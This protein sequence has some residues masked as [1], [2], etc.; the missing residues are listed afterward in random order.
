MQRII[1]LVAA[2]SAAVAAG[3]AELPRATPESVGMSGERLERIT[4]LMQRYVDERRL[5]GIQVLV[6]RDGKVVF[7]RVAGTRGAGDATPLP[8]D[9][10]YR[11]Y[12]MSKPITAVALM[13]LY[14]EGRFQ[15]TDPVAKYAPELARLTVWKDG[16]EVP[17]TN[18]MTM[19]QLLTHTAG[20]SYGFD[21]RDPVD[22]RYAEAG[23]L[24][25]AKD[26]DDF[27][28]RLASVPL[29]YEPG[30]QWHYSV[31]VDVT[32]AIVERLAGQRFDRFLKQ[33]ILDP[34]GMHDTFF[35][36]PEAK[37]PRLLP[38]QRWNRA[39]QALEGIDD[40]RQ[41]RG[42]TFFSGGGGLV[43][44]ARDYLRFAEMLRNGGELDGVRL[45]SPKTVAFMTSDH[46]PASV[47]ASGSGETPGA[48]GAGGN[49]GF[50]FG[51]G[52][53]VVTSAAASGVLGSAGEYNWGGAAGTVF[54]VDPVEDVVVVAMIQLMGSPW[55]LRSELRVLASQALLE[56]RE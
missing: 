20:F 26:L 41:Y 16:A 35:E 36:V 31:A 6:A 38:N 44:T 43:S 29:K 14:E 49:R 24:S 11:I 28:R 46:L 53:G 25:Q 8:A 23:V 15:L 52:F 34:L 17:A 56:T 9:A 13:M 27:L 40:T 18:T 39:Q 37:W 19:Q 5:P 30:T 32:G 3:A 48:G 50:G 21:Q 33:R 42:T 10:L 4:A 55:P 12:S 1:A 7:E 51:L 22:R 54:W 47:R 2:L 45:L